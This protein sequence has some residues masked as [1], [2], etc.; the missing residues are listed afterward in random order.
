MILIGAPIYRRAWILSHWFAAIES[1][2]YPLSDIGFVFEAGPDD[3]ETIEALFAWHERHPEVGVFDVNIN[4]DEVHS[5]N[6]EADQPAHIH[7][8]TWN[9]ERYLTMT[10]LRNSLLQR[11]RCYAPRKYFS[12]DTD[13]LLE[14]PTTI[15]KLDNLNLDVVSPLMYMT[16]IGTTYPGVMTWQIFGQRAYREESYPIGTVFRSDIVMAAKMMSKDV[17]QKVDY[18][19]HYQGEDLGFSNNCAHAGFVLYCASNLYAVHVMSKAHLSIYLHDGDS[20]RNLSF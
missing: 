8:R 4:R 3:E 11:V 9:N 16:P 13:I 17:Y 20:R 6:A 19:F 10:N 15:E 14:D 2:S 5:E 18:S 12:L 7:K 1:Q